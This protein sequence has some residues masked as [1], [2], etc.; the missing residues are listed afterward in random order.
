MIRQ[1]IF[2]LP[3]RENLGRADYIVTAATALAL[4]AVDDWQ[5]WPGGKMLLIGPGGAGKTH[6]A[7]IWA[8]EHGANRIQARDLPKVDLPS[9]AAAGKVVVEDA[10]QIGGDAAAE[11]AMF[12]LHNLLIPGG[13]LLIT[14]N[15][16]PRD[17]GLGLADTLS[18]LQSAGVT[19]INA[20]D[21][22]LLAGV[23]TKLFTDRQLMIAANLIPYLLARMPREIGAARA[24]VAEMDARALADGRPLS[25]RLAAAVLG[26]SLPDE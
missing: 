5:R 20:P 10:Q 21:D 13:H 14:A 24:L 26:E 25:L 3:V 12:H 6:L 8:E 23:L 4:A 19:K 16:P 7:N 9:L 17:W 1:L 11:Q 18:R 22:A 15:T 2:D